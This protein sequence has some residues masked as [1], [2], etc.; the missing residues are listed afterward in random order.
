MQNFGVSNGIVK[1]G[2]YY[3]SFDAPGNDTGTNLGMLRKF[4]VVNN[5]E[6]IE[7]PEYQEDLY[8]GTLYEASATTG[9]PRKILMGHANGVC[10]DGTY[11]YIAPI[12]DWLADPSIRYDGCRYIYKYD[13]DF[14]YINKEEPPASFRS[15]ACI[16]YDWVTH[17]L[18]YR[19]YQSIYNYDYENEQWIF[20][21]TIHLS[22]LG[23]SLSWN[24]DFAIY[25]DHVY[26]GDPTGY[27]AY[28]ELK[29]SHTYVTKSYKLFGLDTTARFFIGELEGM[30][31]DPEGHLYCNIKTNVAT[32]ICNTLIMEL[33]VGE[34]IPRDSATVSSHFHEANLILTEETQKKFALSFNEIRSLLQLDIRVLSGVSSCV[35]VQSGNHVKE[36]GDVTINKGIELQIDGVYECNRIVVN[37]GRLDIITTKDYDPRILEPKIIFNV[38]GDSETALISAGRVGSVDFQGTYSLRIEAPNTASRV[39]LNTGAN[40]QLSMFRS[41]PAFLDG[42]GNVQYV[43]AGNRHHD[44]YNAGYI[45][46]EAFNTTQTMS[47]GRF[48]PDVQNMRNYFDRDAWV[49]RL[50][51]ITPYFGI[52]NLEFKIT[53][54]IPS[55][56]Q[57]ENGDDGIEFVRLTSNVTAVGSA[58]ILPYCGS[59]FTSKEGTGV[60]EVYIKNRNVFARTYNDA[61][62]NLVPSIGTYH[63][64]L[65]VPTILQ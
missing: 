41:V 50:L 31:F 59:T 32:G 57:N 47:I 56:A 65:A 40:M 55:D 46:G 12:Y 9:W 20:Y 64:S 30:E 8:E 60:V 33:P 49:C 44:I 61:N 4:D 7:A 11:V 52:L 21:S 39:V 62:G 43:A 2:D 22:D 16:T 23:T 36:L 13:A 35:Y 25:N 45:I 63:I 48:Q 10:Y 17:K 24:Q 14:N 28:G 26:V 3:Y 42:R 53:N 15:P 37:N 51:Q 19:R 38:S 34:V 6:V 5:C 54:N 18:Y 58:N 1:I 27:I 29:P